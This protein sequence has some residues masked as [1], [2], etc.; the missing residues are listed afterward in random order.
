MAIK[1]K[2]KKNEFDEFEV[3]WLENGLL[4]ENKTYYTDD[5]EDATLTKAAMEKEV[6]VRTCSTCGAYIDETNYCDSCGN[7]LKI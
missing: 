5:R 3:Q 6:K 7:E 4:N 2:I 1:I